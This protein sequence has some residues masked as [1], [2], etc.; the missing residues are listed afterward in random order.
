M[1]APYRLKA[2][3]FCLNTTEGRNQEPLI[4]PEPKYTTTAGPFKVAS[5]QRILWD[6]S[7]FHQTCPKQ[8]FVEI[9]NAPAT[10]GYHWFANTTKSRGSGGEP[11]AKGI[12]PVQSNSRGNSAYG[13]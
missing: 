8:V 4:P 13:L 11:H 10:S 6:L 5:Y 9:K 1:E 3:P 7:T 2:S 12:G